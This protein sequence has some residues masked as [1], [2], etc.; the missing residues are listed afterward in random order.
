MIIETFTTFVSSY[1][2]LSYINT[3]QE[4]PRSFDITRQH[5]LVKNIL[6]ENFKI[7]NL[8]DLLVERTK[9]SKKE[10]I[11]YEKVNN[12]WI[13]YTHS[14]FFKEACKVAK[15]L[16]TLGL[17]KGD[18]VSISGDTCM[19]WCIIDFGCQL[20]GIYDENKK[21]GWCL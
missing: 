20:A 3:E 1:A 6:D 10:P 13:M 2:L 14:Y 12:K 5:V 19:K 7:N 9:L 11:F 21:K 4:R 8:S 18:K 16:L 17:N 15:G